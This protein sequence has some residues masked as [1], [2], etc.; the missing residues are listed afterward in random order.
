MVM[1]S[2]GKGGKGHHHLSRTLSLERESIKKDVS[3]SQCRFCR[4]SSF[5]VRGDLV[6]PYSNPT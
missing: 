5:V 4:F 2:S 1:S 3:S 6:L